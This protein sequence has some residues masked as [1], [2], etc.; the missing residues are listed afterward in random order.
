MNKNILNR[1][2]NVKMLERSH[3]FNVRDKNYDDIQRIMENVLEKDLSFS[4]D[5]KRVGRSLL[6]I[7]YFDTNVDKEQQKNNRITILQEAEKR[8]Y[9]QINGKLTDIQVEQLWDELEKKINEQSNIGDLS[10]PMLPIEETIQGIKSLI[11]ERGYIVKIESVQEFVEN[12]I[13]QYDRLPK[14][15]EFNSIV[16]GYIIMVNEDNH[17]DILEKDVIKSER[18]IKISEQH[19]EP[20][21][22]DLPINSYD[23]NVSVMKDTVERKKCPSC[24]NEGLIHE[25]DDKSVILLDY[26]KIYAKKNC[27]SQCGYEWRTH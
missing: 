7:N 2:R 8:I 3:S 22:V 18:N 6:R 9:I 25:M 10:K 27:C 19:L 20:S 17:M 24:G 12:F 5:S 26:P 11:D 1:V 4:T 15:D 23:S 13:E 14:K 21:Q 16:K